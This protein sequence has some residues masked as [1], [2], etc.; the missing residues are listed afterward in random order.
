MVA[1]GVGLPLA[2]LSLRALA[3]AARPGRPYLAGAPLLIAH[4]GGAALAPENTL[5]AFRQALEWWEADIVELDVHPTREGEAVVIHDATVDRTTD[6][7]GPVAGFTLEALRKLDAGYR[8]TADGG[9]SFPYRGRGVRIPTLREVLEAFPAARV[10][11]EIKDGRAQPGVRRAIEAL[12]A[13]QRVLVASARRRNR[14]RFADYAG[15]TSASAEELYAF[16]AL[17]RARATRLFRPRVDAFQLPEQHRGRQVLSPRFVREAQAL[18]LAVHVWTVNDEADM[19]RLL[20]W[21]VDGIITDR[22]DLLA[23]VLHERTGRPLPPGPP[24]PAAGR[25]GD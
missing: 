21:G 24:A 13:S 2:A 3:P 4:R 16:L 18:N 14:A 11:V 7:S 23:R 20:D 1:A 9:R 15:A 22:P 25:A 8:F 12:N 19:H 5:P 6:G 17:H 10:N